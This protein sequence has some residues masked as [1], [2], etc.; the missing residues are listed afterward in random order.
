MS[1]SGA[2]VRDCS[3]TISILI[4]SQ[5]EREVM[6]GNGE[7]CAVPG[8]PAHHRRGAIVLC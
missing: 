7:L 6:R 8:R 1:Q 2:V 4:V 3:C 5:L